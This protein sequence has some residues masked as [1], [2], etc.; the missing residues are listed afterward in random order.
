MSQL[1]YYDA[2]T[3]TWVPLLV[4]A[5]GFQGYQGTTGSQGAQGTIGSQGSQGAQ[6]TT[7]SQGAQGTTGSQGSQGVTGSF[8]GTTTQQIITSN[9]TTSTS[10]TT[11]ALQVAGGAG[12]NGALYANTIISTQGVLMHGNTIT[13]NVILSAGTNGLSVGPLTVAAGGSLTVA[14]GARHIL[15]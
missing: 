6:G 11:G 2:N 1:K 5:Q 7:G 4:G 13:G 8:S 10:T 3:S 9:T 12:I 14:A 15:L